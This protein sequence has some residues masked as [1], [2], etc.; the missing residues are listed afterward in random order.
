MAGLLK[1][2]NKLIYGNEEG[3]KPQ[4]KPAAA[5]L[6]EAVQRE[7]HL[8]NS[9]R[10]MASL[11]IVSAGKLRTEL[12]KLVMQSDELGKLALKF[13][14]EGQS[15]QA[16]RYLAL[17]LAINEKVAAVTEQYETADKSAQQLI[18]EAQ[19]QSKVAKEAAQ[20]LPRRVLQVEINKMLEDAR[21]LETQAAA[22]L[23]GKQSYKALAE[24]IE[25]RTAALMTQQLLS[26]TSGTDMEQE[27]AQVMNEA[28]FGQAY[29]QLQEKAQESGGQIIDAEYTEVTNPAD[30]AKAL[31]NKAPFGGL[32]GRE[33]RILSRQPAKE[34]EEEK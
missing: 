23:A 32:L 19:E 12:Q 13:E 27:V 29:K 14:S 26:D 2:W 8:A 11:T 18:K 1:W 15:E 17:Q 20:D 21:N 25:T 16:K 10:E 30:K 22:Q 33:V 3:E 6:Q 24:S 7:V 4:K 34:G 28:E 9:K 31:L 5:D